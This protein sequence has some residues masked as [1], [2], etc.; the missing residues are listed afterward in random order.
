M[1]SAPTVSAS[2]DATKSTPSEPDVRRA[3]PGDSEDD[4]EPE[5][6]SSPAFTEAA[7]AAEGVIKTPKMPLAHPLKRP[8]TVPHNANMGGPVLKK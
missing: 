7:A 1:T 6:P 3:P 8:Y 4:A 5:H 2:P